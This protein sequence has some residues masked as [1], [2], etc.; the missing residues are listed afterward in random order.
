MGTESASPAQRVS[1]LFRECLFED[2]EARD[3]AVLAEGVTINAGF[4]PARL[5]A[6][7]ERLVALL[8]EI[9]TDDFLVQGRGASLLALC[10]AR[11]GQ[12]WG[13]QR[14]CQELLLLALASGLATYTFPR[15]LWGGLLGGV[16]WVQFRPPATA[17]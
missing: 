11:D 13:E 12:Q 16:P 3:D 10:E 7:R 17:A 6:A 1:E 14:N 9:V 8:R 4:H 5:A 15:L 2:D